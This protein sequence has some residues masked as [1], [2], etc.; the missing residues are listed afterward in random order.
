MYIQ[1]N[2]HDCIVVN[3]IIV[4]ISSMGH[5]IVV[6]IERELT[7]WSIERANSMVYRELI[8]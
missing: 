3:E 1:N 2:H 6:Y 5:S 7:V 8:V 4:T